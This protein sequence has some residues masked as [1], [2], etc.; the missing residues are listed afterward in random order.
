MPR[1]RTIKG[2]NQTTTRSRN[3]GLAFENSL[4]ISNQMYLRKRI[5]VINKRATPVKVVRSVG[6]FVKEGYFEESSTVDYDGVY[7]A[8]SIQFDAKSILTLDRFDL[9]RVK[10]HQYEHLLICHQ[11]GAFCFLLIEFISQRKIYLLKFETLRSYMEV[12]KK[13]GRKSIRIEDFDVYAYEVEKYLGGRVPVDYLTT[14]DKA[15]F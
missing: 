14:V 2:T 12:S 1:R 7:R 11:L 10:K 3:D 4:Y 5:A 9:S 6:S 8:K 15:F 13:G